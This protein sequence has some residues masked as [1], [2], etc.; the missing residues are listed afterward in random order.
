MVL[1]SAGKER[2]LPA[3][4]VCQA[5]PFALAYAGRI[6]LVSLNTSRP[7]HAA[8]T[9]A[10][11]QILERQ[12]SDLA[13]NIKDEFIVPKTAEDY[14][15]VL[16][17]SKTFRMKPSGVYGSVYESP[18]DLKS[19]RRALFACVI[20]GI[21]IL[22]IIISMSIGRNN[23]GNTSSEVI[24]SLST[25]VERNIPVLDTYYGQ[26]S[27][28]IDKALSADNN[29]YEVSIDS[30]SMSLVR[31]PDD[32]TAEEVALYYSNGLNS[33]STD[34][35]ATLL[36]G[37]WFFTVDTSGTEVMKVKYAD[38]TSNTAERAIATAMDEQGLSGKN[39]NIISQGVDSSKNTYKYGTY[40]TDD[41]QTRYWR[42]ACC[43]LSNVYKVSGMPKNALYVGI[44]LSDGELVTS[45]SQS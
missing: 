31:I 41:N 26:S 14:K 13:F 33:L 11:S 29:I 1:L 40:V 21:I 27:S 20:A 2:R 37:A 3:G 19:V 17:S 34:Q 44:T 45:S 23:A 42:V 35:L 43:A 28:Y 4:A 24:R 8:G 12:R 18:N 15:P 25:P 30:D 16:T 38:F 22:A 10:G 39:P 9:N 36:R 6:S 5:F 7:V 32:V